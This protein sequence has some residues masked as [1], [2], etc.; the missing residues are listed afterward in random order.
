MNGLHSVVSEVKK[1]LD[2]SDDQLRDGLPSGPFGNDI[3]HDD[4]PDDPQAHLPLQLVSAL[5]ADHG[6]RVSQG[7]TGPPLCRPEVLRELPV[8]HI[9]SGQRGL[10][11]LLRALGLLL[12]LL[13]LEQLY[14]ELR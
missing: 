7:V 11:L 14:P 8:F 10:G 13:R 2:A 12:R 4:T 6:I 1:R 5:G 9:Q 3:G